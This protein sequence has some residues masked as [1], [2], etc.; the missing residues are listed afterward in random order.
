MGQAA[1]VLASNGA[2]LG[3]AGLSVDSFALLHAETITDEKSAEPRSHAPKVTPGFRDAT[4]RPSSKP[5]ST[6]A[7]T[8]GS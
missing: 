3:T 2:Q 4:R 8:F 5:T 6:E 1:P 7:T